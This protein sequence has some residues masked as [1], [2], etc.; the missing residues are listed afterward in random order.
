MASNT[1]PTFLQLRGSTKKRFSRDGFQQIHQDQA[2]NMANNDATIDI[3]LEQVSTTNGLRPLHTT[4]SLRHSPSNATARNDKK[5]FFRGRR[6]KPDAATQ[7]TG[8]VG[9]DGEE[10]TMTTMGKIYDKIFGFS[11]I[12]RY[13]LYVLPLGIL[14]AVPIIVGVII[15]NS[16]D[17]GRPP[18]LA[19]VSLIW[20]FTWIE[21]VWLSLWVAKL[22]AHFL[23]YVFQI[24]VGVVSSGV[25][26][27]ASVIRKLEIPLSL[28]GWAVTSLATFL[29]LMTLN[30]YQQRL[31]VEWQANGSKGTD[32]TATQKWEGIVQN[33]LAAALVSSLVFLGEKTII[34]LISI[35]YHRKQFNAKIKE[36][37]RHVYI[38]GLL[39]DASR[40][41]FPAYC[42]EFAEEDYIIADQLQISTLGGRRKP[43]KRNG[44]ATP[45]RFIQD[46]GRFGDKVTS[47]FGNVAHE[48]TGKEVFNPN[49]SHS[50][51]V[52]ALEK[53]AASEALARRIWMSLVVDGHESLY[54]HD[55][56]DVLGAE[57]REEAEEA[58][59]VLDRDGNGDVSLDEMIATVTEWGRE[60]KAIANSMVDVAQAINVLD[61]LLMTVVLIAV[62]FVF[63][64]FLNS[65]FTTTL[66]TTG[67]ALLSLSFVFSV[68]AQEVLGSCIFLFVKHPFDI[69]DRVDIGLDQYVVE[70]ISLLFTVFRRATG[71][72]VGQLN[73]YPNIVLNSL[74]LENVSRSKAMSEQITLDVQYNTTFDD[75]Q[76]LKNELKNFVT[77]KDNSRDF[78]PDLEVEVLGT[79][80]MSKLQLRVEIKHK[81]NWA[82]ETQRSA[83]RSKFMCAL[84]AATRAVPIYGPGGGTDVAGS[85]ANPNYSVA[86]SESAHKEHAQVTAETRENARL[87]SHKKLQEVKDAT[88]LSPINGNKMGMAGLTQH[89]AKLVDDLTARD[90]ASDPV[91]DE[92]WTS[93]RED[94][95]TLGGG[96]SS[97]DHQ[98]L[99]DVRGLLRREGTLGKRR[100][101]DHPAMRLRPPTIQ[102]S[103]PPPAV[104]SSYATAAP[105]QA[106]YDPQRGPA[107]T[108]ST[109]PTAYRSQSTRSQASPYQPS[110]NLSSATAASTFAPLS[111]STSSPAAIS[112]LGTEMSQV[113]HEMSAHSSPTGQAGNTYRGRSGTVAGRPSLTGV[114][115][116]DDE[117]LSRRGYL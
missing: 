27:Y 25:R 80:D 19:G 43:H 15:Q 35:N 64:A 100:P 55:I 84:V 77:D 71:P 23:P 29:P 97:I 17:D 18:I 51:V 88:P 72:K 52:T 16:S 59:W 112:G 28:V 4:A 87:V 93:G 14:I 37:K 101:S 13:F 106:A 110:D 99:E 98:D 38:L 50:I 108:Y 42:N 113:P 41:L 5:S 63:V 61:R 83:R 107:A 36:S 94:T 48:I 54:N 9:Y 11:I 31:K 76:I 8:R 21:V 79:S 46:V 56:I 73:Q 104:G 89:D 49:G 78:Q 62:I 57:R 2:A 66:A 3:P 24:F 47:A 32:P 114:D 58:F 111:V 86:I 30:P 53:R 91:R 90:P 40:Q 1:S 109:T 60:R 116:E 20:F 96:R 45:L 85:A 102:A 95:S 67:T 39:Y 10:D 115:E 92:A 70:H 33:I 22:V 26:K 81:G 82:N 44:S 75:I 74:A 34:Q 103:G 6:T 7:G 12:T 117:N 68:T 69:G 105:P 65:N